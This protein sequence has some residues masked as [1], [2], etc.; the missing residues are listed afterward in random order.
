MGWGSGNTAPCPDPGWTAC[1]ALRDPA[2]V[3]G[4][5]T[6]PSVLWCPA[7]PDSVMGVVRLQGGQAVSGNVHARPL[8]AGSPFLITGSRDLASPPGT[9]DTRG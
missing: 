4:G 2:Q 5:P 7:Q 8:L 6:D 9:A 3:Q 1:L